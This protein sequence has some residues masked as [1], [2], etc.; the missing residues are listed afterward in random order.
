MAGDGWVAVAG[1]AVGGLLTGLVAWLQSSSH[2]RFELQRASD[3]R[4][5]VTDRARGEWEQAEQVRRRQE[6]LEVYTGYQLAA[7]RYENAV[8]DVAALPR[9]AGGAAFE[10]AQG[11]YDRATEL[12]RLLAPSATAALVLEQRRLFT[13]LAAAA[14]RGRYQETA[15]RPAIVAASAPLLAAMR[16]DL[17]TE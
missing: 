4:R 10:A 1:V 8:R 2:Q 16:L 3:E 6:L 15:A 13:D 17:S 14:L 9:P 7:D 5:W 11:E 12:I